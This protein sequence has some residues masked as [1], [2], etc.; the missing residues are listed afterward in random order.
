MSTAKKNDSVDMNRDPITGTPGSHPVG[1]GL[2]SAGGA[3]VGAVAGAVFGPVGMLVGGA[4]GAI[5]GAAVGHNAAERVDPTGEAEYWKD[6]HSTR[7]YAKTGASYDTDY[8]P[9]Y[10][11]GVDS[12]NTYGQRRWDDTL[13]SDLAR[14]WDS[15]KSTSSL[16]WDDAKPAVR[17][18]WD[19]TDRTYSAYSA[20]DRYY[21]SRFQD[22]PYKE[23]GDKFE[24]WR[25][26]YRYGTYARSNNPNRDWDDKLESDLE[27][28][29]DKAKGT[30]SLA[31]NRAKNATKD[32]WHSVE[33][34][35]P[36]DADNDGR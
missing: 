31:W 25:S 17:D 8:K 26:A 13:E 14:D 16:N 28:G 10:L 20:S 9:A 18:A 22:A 23:T 1:T 5:A 12:R 6:N 35:L 36:G 15:R 19:R 3:T 21:E 7:T 11:Y 33:R 27:R 30:S 2:G 32:A 24:D 34:A 29:W 4:V